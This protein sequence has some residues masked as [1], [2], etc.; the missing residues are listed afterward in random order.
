MAN[1]TRDSEC[2]VNTQRKCRKLSIIPVEK[3]EKCIQGWN[4]HLKLNSNPINGGFCLHCRATNE[5]RLKSSLPLTP[6]DFVLIFHTYLYNKPVSAHVAPRRG[7]SVSQLFFVETVWYPT[8]RT[9]L[10]FIVLETKYNNQRV[11]WLTCATTHI[12]I[13]IFSRSLLCTLYLPFVSFPGASLFT[14]LI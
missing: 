4:L 11:P 14:L 3:C 7:Q 5:Q 13:S 9:S 12:W 10:R 2:S 6:P 1:S 8:T